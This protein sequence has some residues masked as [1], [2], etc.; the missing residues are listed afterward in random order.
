MTRGYLRVFMGIVT[1]K[2][3]FSMKR[4]YKDLWVTQ[5]NV[6]EKYNLYVCFLKA[7][8]IEKYTS[9]KMHQISLF[10]ITVEMFLQ[11]QDFEP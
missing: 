5:K 9:K 3:Y 8:K 11:F 10:H 6:I 2:D 7:F 1:F 4:G